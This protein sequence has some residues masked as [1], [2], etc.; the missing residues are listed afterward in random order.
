[1]DMDKLVSRLE[2]LRK[3]GR[4]AEVEKLEKK[5]EGLLEEA[6]K[7]PTSLIIEIDMGPLFARDFTEDGFHM[8]KP[9]QRKM[10]LEVR[11]VLK[12]GELPIGGDEML[13]RAKTAGCAT[14]QE[15]GD[16]IATYLNSPA[17]KEAFMALRDSGCR[18]IILPNEDG[19]WVHDSS[20]CRYVPVLFLHGGQ[21][22]SAL[23]YLGGDC[24]GSAARFLVPCKP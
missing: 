10:K 4:L 5:L 21:W 14:S 9:R 19:L 15:E 2:A 22:F 7:I 20:G 18:Y 17:G 12:G 11:R 6:G 16:H 24:F 13:K 3:A 23:S 1:M 8:E